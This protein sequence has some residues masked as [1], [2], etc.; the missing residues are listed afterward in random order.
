MKGIILAGGAGTRLYP[1]TAATS[2][3]LLPIYDKPL[4]Y[5]PLSI[6]ML[7]GIRD[8]LVICSPQDLPN[9]QRLLGQGDR[10]GLNISY[11]VQEHPA[12]LAHAFIL[13]RQF[14]GNDSV[15]L[16]L[17]DNIFYSQG[18]GEF[19]KNA[20]TLNSGATVFGHYVKDPHRF[21]VVELADNNEVLSIEEKPERPKSNYAVTGLYIYNNDVVEIAKSI[22]PSDRG[23]LEITDVNNVYLAH[24][25]LKVK[26]FGRGMLW[27]DAGTFDSML[28]AGNLVQALELRQGLKIACIEEIA[29]SNG[30]ISADHIHEIATGIEH[31]N[32]G[33]YLLG[34]V[35]QE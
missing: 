31:T 28:A 23:E 17:G 30:W 25:E 33:K 22:K 8:I 19:L 20:V 14:I 12:G 21:G 27:L 9:Y 13:G 1:I 11:E 4:V 6:L 29:F 3:Q 34:L 24:R 16:V 35:A 10:F 26:L 2:K 15:T 32:Y 18:L 7:M 5:Y